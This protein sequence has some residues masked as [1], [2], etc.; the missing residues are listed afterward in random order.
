LLAFGLGMALASVQAFAHGNHSHGPAL[1]D[2]ER[3]ASEGIFADKD[4]K[5]LHV[6][7]VTLLIIGAILFHALAAGLFRL[8]L[9]NRIKVGKTVNSC[10]YTYSGYKILQYASGKKGVRYLF[11][12]QHAAHR[13]NRSASYPSLSARPPVIHCP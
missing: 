5:L 1:T 9:Q 11:E 10:K 3:Q 12:C 7:G 2:I 6:G 13:D 8:L 4:V